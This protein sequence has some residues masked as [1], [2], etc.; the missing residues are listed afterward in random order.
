LRVFYFRR[1]A[2]PRWR[3]VPVSFLS[4]GLGKLIGK[5]KFKDAMALVELLLEKL[6]QES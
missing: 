1:N 3:N 6:S 4:W 2:Q 5:Y